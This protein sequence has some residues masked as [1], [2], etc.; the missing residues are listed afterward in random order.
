MKIRQCMT[1]APKVASP[2][3]NAREI[4]WRMRTSRIRHLPVVDSSSALIGV[5]SE[6][7]LLPLETLGEIE[8]LS[9]SGF[10]DPSVRDLMT[11]DVKVVHP[12]DT[13]HVAVEL[14]LKH[15]FGA[16]P[17]VEPGPTPA[18]VGILSPLDVLRAWHDLST[19]VLARRGGAGETGAAT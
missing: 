16:L 11:Q 19:R 17:V 18:L 5:I 13:V 10:D 12:E 14:F 4:L 7:D 9:S 6:R 2:D 1:R 8:S 15:R 3:D